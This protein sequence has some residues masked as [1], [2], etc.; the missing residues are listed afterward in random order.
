[1]LAF[2]LEHEYGARCSFRPLSIFKAYWLEAES[3][4]ELH[5][6]VVRRTNSIAYD[7]DQRPVL[8]ADS[9]WTV[10]ALKQNYPAISFLAWNEPQEQQFAS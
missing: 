9:Q 4:A 2:R 8:L 3:P 7:R 5:Q 1:V 6:F 10:N